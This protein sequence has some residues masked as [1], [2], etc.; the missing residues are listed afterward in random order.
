MDKEFA[1]S[2]IKNEIGII[3]KV[4]KVK[5]VANI[6]ND[7][8][9]LSFSNKSSRGKAYNNLFTRFDNHKMFGNISNIE[10]KSDYLIY[11]SLK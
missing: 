5:Y 8:L 3:L 9:C 4:A 11:I 7:K 2:L 1:L 10:Q 6:S